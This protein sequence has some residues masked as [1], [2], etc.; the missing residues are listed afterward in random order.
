MPKRQKSKLYS[1][2]K[3]RK[4]RFKARHSKSLS[5]TSTQTAR[6]LPRAPSQGTP[7][8]LQSSQKKYYSVPYRSR[9]EKNNPYHRYPWSIARCS[10]NWNYFTQWQHVFYSPSPWSQPCRSPTTEG[11]ASREVKPSSPRPTLSCSR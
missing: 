9:Y 8:E 11:A 1:R 10:L 6:M 2:E 5:K 4:R 3:T 7:I